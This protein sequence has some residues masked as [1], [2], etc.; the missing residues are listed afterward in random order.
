GRQVGLDGKPFW[1]G[2]LL[3]I[4]NT[5]EGSELHPNEDWSNIAQARG[6]F[7]EFYRRMTSRPEGG[8]VSFYF[9]PCEFIHREFWDG[10]NFARGANP[11]REKWKLPPMKTPEERER[12]FSYQEEL[13][14]SIKSLPRAE[15]NTASQAV[16]IFQDD[17]QGRAY[18]PEDLA[19]IA[20]RVDAD[21]SFQVHD[22]FTLAASEVFFLL[23]RHVAAMV[24]TAPPGAI[25]LDDT[26]YGPASPFEGGGALTADVS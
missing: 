24:R 6:R 13:V 17:A 9:H 10:V 26:P 4:F 5:S 22:R 25:P 18:G 11:P 19:R 2:G 8:V 14:A 20:R 21:V 15:F 12:A 1:Y 3:N 16:Q 23:N 7:Q